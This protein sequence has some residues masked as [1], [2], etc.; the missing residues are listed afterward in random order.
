MV[1]RILDALLGRLSDPS[2]HPPVEHHVVHG[3]PVRVINT[4]PEIRT[5]EVIE[6]LTAALDLI[7]RY[8]PARYRRL[9]KDCG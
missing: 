2:D 1:R 8:A 9:R 4:R 7:A 5:A 3:L 6:R